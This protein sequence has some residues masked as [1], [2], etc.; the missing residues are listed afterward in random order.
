MKRLFMLLCAVVAFAACEQ[1]FI[2]VANDVAES[3]RSLSVSFEGDDTR[4]QLNEA[5]K[6]VWTEGDL[7]SVFYRSTVNEKWQFM[8]KTGDRTGDIVPVDNSVNP[9]ATHNHVVVVYPYNEDYFYNTETYNIEASIPAVQHYLKDS[10]GTNGTLMVS[11]SEFNKVSLKSVCG[12]LKLQL[13][14]E[15]EVVKSITL[16]GNDGEQVAGL[17]YVDSANAASTLASVMGEAGDEVGGVLVRPGAILTEVTLDCGE[18]VT[19]GAEATAFYIALPPQTFEKGLTVEIEDVDGCVM[20]QSTDKAVSVERNHIQPMAAFEFAPSVPNNHIW[21]TSTDGKIVTPYSSDVFGANIK[22]NTYSDGKGIITFDGDVTTIGERAFYNCTSLTSV[23]IP[24][25]VTTIGICAFRDCH[26]LTSVTI[27]DSVTS[28]GDG[29]FLSCYN[30]TGFSGKFAEDN[31][32]ILVVDGTL[33][34]LA[35]SC[36]ATEYIIPDYVT[37]IELSAFRDCQSLTS[38]TISDSV[39]SI[40]GYAFYECGSLTS[41]YCKPTTPPAGGQYMFDQSASGRKIYVPYNSVNAYK[42]ADGWSRYAS[43]I[44]GYNFETGDIFRQELLY[45]S[46]DGKIVTPY[47]LDAFGA[48]II[49]NTYDNGSGVI[50]FDAPIISIGENAFYCCYSLAS[51]TIPNSVTSIGKKAFEYCSKL[52]SVAIPNSVTLIGESAFS[53]CSKLTSVTIPNSVTSIREATFAFC[54]SLK[55]VTIPNGVTSIGRDAFRNCSSM[56]SVTIPDSVTSIGE[57]AF[58]YCIKLTS[59]T[60]PSSV[61]SIGK[62]AFYGC[63]C[64]LIIDS[65]TLVEKNYTT[66]NYPT[67]DD[68]WLYGNESTKITI[69]KNVTKIGNRAF[70]GCSS[71]TSI[72]IP[73]SV[74]SIGES[75]FIGCSNLTS[76]TI[77]DGVTS[78]S[79]ESFSG[80]SSLTSVTIPNSVASIGYKAFYNCISLKSVYCKPT[81]PPTAG[82]NIFWYNESGSWIIRCKIYVPKASVNAYKSASNWSDYAENIVGYDF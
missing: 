41:V 79:D 59:I 52:T 21:Y 1:V 71:L 53:S 26:G 15:G 75:A 80:C 45:T 61:T 68:G 58:N 34:A 78:I 43:D 8:G 67:R 10:Y 23:T 20:E 81:T 66:S 44:V 18:G 50:K 77:P 28:I 2:D 11:S 29:V 76:V 33:I 46:T 30:L 14:G 73:N 56:T 39:T 9:P 17:I 57:H 48:N 63:K 5:Q 47:S 7:L 65:Q 37:T 55:N 35:P 27:P 16:R 49:S 69:G 3:D 4:V 42:S 12:W 31:G 6:T 22:S 64:E 19:L 36:G 54:G 40:R 62:W 72:T 32:R 82:N 38:V 51:V 74:T 70:R 25:S 24:D 13:T 60:I